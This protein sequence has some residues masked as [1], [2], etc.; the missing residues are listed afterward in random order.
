M[1]MN[2]DIKPFDKKKTKQKHVHFY[3]F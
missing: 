3:H 2:Q 1:K